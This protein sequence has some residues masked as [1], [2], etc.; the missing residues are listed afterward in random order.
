MRWTQLVPYAALAIAVAEFIYSR[1]DKRA[2]RRHSV[3]ELETERLKV[4]LSGPAAVLGEYEGQGQVL[5]TRLREV[6]EQRDNYA[7]QVEELRAELTQ[8][9]RTSERDA[10]ANRAEIERLKRRIAELERANGHV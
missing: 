7:V 1:L 9:K 5:L 10:K 4:L 3:E 2:S 8:V 6:I